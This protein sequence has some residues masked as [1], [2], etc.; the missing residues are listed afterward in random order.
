MLFLVRSRDHKLIVY[1]QVKK[2]QLFDLNKNPWELL[3]DDLA[4]DASMTRVR[5]D[6]MKRLRNFQKE[7][8]DPLNLNDP[9]KSKKILPIWE[10]GR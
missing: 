9:N 10:R 2:V 3:S 1:P 5:E 7:L 4:E 8:D 6:L